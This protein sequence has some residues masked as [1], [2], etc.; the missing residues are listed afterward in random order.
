MVPEALFRREKSNSEIKTQAR[1][2]SLLNQGTKSSTGKEQ[3]IRKNGGEKANQKKQPKPENENYRET[4][5]DREN[6]ELKR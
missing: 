4:Q 2:G 5:L 6:S 1:Q 3:T